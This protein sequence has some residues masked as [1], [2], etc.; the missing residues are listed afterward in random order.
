MYPVLAR[1][2]EISMACSFSVPTITGNSRSPDSSV[3]FPAP[4]LVTL[5]SNVLF[6]RTS[7]GWFILNHVD[8]AT[9]ESKFTGGRQS[10][11]RAAFSGNYP[12]SLRCAM[13]LTP[14]ERV[15]WNL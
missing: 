3:S 5:F 4:L 1:S 9:S 13:S 14:D 7:Y 12:H 2:L 8:A 6:I 11:Q 15:G 10:T